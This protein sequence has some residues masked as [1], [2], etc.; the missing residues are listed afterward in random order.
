[1]T[2]MKELANE[3]RMGYYQERNFYNFTSAAGK[4]YV[5]VR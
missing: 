1:M 3:Y 5:E 4:A 2:G